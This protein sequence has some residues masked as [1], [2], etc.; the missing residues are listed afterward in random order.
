VARFVVLLA[1]SLAIGYFG[2]WEYSK[3]WLQTTFGDPETQAAVA[4]PVLELVAFECR[5]RSDV[6]LVEAVGTV[7]SLTDH[8][9]NV[10]AYVELRADDGQLIDMGQAF[11]E[12]TPLAAHNTSDFKVL[13]RYDS[14]AGECAVR[15]TDPG[16]HEL[17]HTDATEPT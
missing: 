9:L 4:P 7:R 16:H 14:S 15:F 13:V 10:F 5:K 8:N 11:L 12:R 2:G 6:P 3:Q 17:V 1:G